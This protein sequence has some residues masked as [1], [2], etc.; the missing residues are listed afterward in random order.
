MQATLDGFYNYLDKF[1]P[2]KSGKNRF[3]W[4][5]WNELWGASTLHT[6]ER[7]KYYHQYLLHLRKQSELLQ[8]K[9]EREFFEEVYGCP[10]N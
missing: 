2:Q 5:Y 9:Y 4:E 8:L 3:F 1:Y 7:I 6:K 10:K